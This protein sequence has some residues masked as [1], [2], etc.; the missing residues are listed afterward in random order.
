MLK[1]PA[2][3]F[4]SQDFIVGTMMMSD[5][6]LGRY[7]RVLAYTHT[8]GGYICEKEFKKFV[9]EEDDRIIEKFRVDGEGN[10]YNERLLSEMLKRNKY[11]ESRRNNRLKSTNN[12]I[13]IYLIRNP[14]TNLTKIGSSN[15]PQRRLIELKNQ[16]N[17]MDLFILASVSGVE[18]TLESKLQK[19]YKDYNVLNE[20]F[21]LNEK[22]IKNIVE[23]N[24]MKYH[25]IEHMEN[26]NENVNI[27]KD[28]NNKEL[29]VLKTKDIKDELFNQF[30]L[31]Y[32]KKVAKKQ[33]MSKFKTIVKDQTTLD[34]ILFDISRR[35][36][37]DEWSKNNGQFI[38]HP[39]TY[40]NQERWNDEV[41]ITQK[42]KLSFMDL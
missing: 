5:E 8:K 37:T 33:T 16:M 32:P 15:N 6:E 36:K 24:D 14:K 9:K 2:F 19:E 23:K 4:Y 21:D 20:W 25:M 27:N 31:A 12:D 28:E 26:E 18:R 40:L 17:E 38:P 41:V 39:S 10:Y 29:E 7:I 13:S 11:T 3:L 1:D 35:L 42:K 22:D 34:T 30:W